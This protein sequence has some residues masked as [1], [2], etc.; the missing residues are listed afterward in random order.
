MSAQMR[1]RLHSKIGNPAVGADFFPRPDVVDRLYDDLAHNRGSRRLFAL[2][3][4]G[5]TS[6]L[7]ELGQRL[8]ETAGLTVIHVDV[9]GLNRFQDFL[10]KVFAQIPTDN[11]FQQI[12]QR[13]HNNSGI[14]ALMPWLLPR[15]PK[16]NS[17]QAKQDFVI[18]FHHSAIWAGDI[19]AA[20]KEA[21]P[22]VLMI[23]ELPFMMR[24]M[25]TR[26]YKPADV[27]SFLATLR[28]WRMNSGVRMLLSGSIGLAQLAR[29]EKV[30][31][32]DHIADMRPVRLPPLR[33]DAAVEMVEALARGEG[34][35]GWQRRLSE[36]IV[37]ASAE[38]WPI[39]L[40]FGFDEVRRDGTRDPASVRAIIEREVRPALDET[41]YQQF[42]TRLARYDRDE[43]AA[44]AILRAVAGAVQQ[45]ATFD[46]IDNILKKIGAGALR[47]R[48]DLL[49]AL[50]EDDF[51]D[52]DTTSQIA[53]PA[54]RLVPIW[55]RARAWGR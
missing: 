49:E 30:H 41:F 27:E 50:R 22:I 20:L 39:F 8:R 52:L 45:F 1:L 36:A 46:A 31:V 10:G 29:I 26:G 9:Q 24:N 33:H 21:G 19:A 48:D 13:L 51:I 35:M 18:E 38:T 3:R 25:I 15:A 2:R 32:A 12:L 34:M 23:D 43:T 53:K 5:K 40:Q 44:R 54:S 47:K 7:L 17:A 28:D 16:E 55:V 14:Q 37:E 42:A 4:I 11:R 6:V